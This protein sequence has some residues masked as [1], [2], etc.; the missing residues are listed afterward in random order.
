MTTTLKR[1]A[2]LNKTWGFIFALL[3]FAT[4][5]LWVPPAG[6]AQS[7]TAAQAGDAPQ[8]AMLA[9]VQ[10]WVA[11]QAGISTRQVELGP[12]D[13]RLKVPGCGS[14]LSFEYAFGGREMVR[15]HC[16]SPS[17]DLYVKARVRELRA[18]L[19]VT[20]A[21][22]A[23]TVLERTDLEASLSDDPVHG[24]RVDAAAA[25]GKRL[26]IP[27]SAGATISAGDLEEIR[28]IYRL[29]SAVTAGS[30][31]DPAQWRA[32]DVAR[33]SIPA[34][35]VLQKPP[36]PGAR[37]A[38]D[39]AAGRVLAQGDIAETRQALVAKENIAAG[40]PLD[41]ELFAVRTLNVPEGS[42]P[43]IS[44]F[45][46][47]EFQSATRNI[48]AGEP[49]LATD[50]RPAVIVNRGQTVLVTLSAAIGLEISVRAEAM[51]DGRLSES[52]RL[53]NPESGKLLYGRVTG[54]GTARA[55]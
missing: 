30:P 10:R 44:E 48:P 29:L 22:T 33:S 32:D 36:G 26:R 13:G 21:L 15:V 37:Y 47:L 28:R 12:L 31:T 20:R 2:T 38:R 49:L 25:I 41:K 11:A 50:L 35:A 54:R 45:A 19:R 9:G 8:S 18:V 23:G 52:I 6:A 14:E 51:E 4:P 42:R 34:A 55:L 39:L 53:R 27:L 43:F 40:R 16:A 5:L 3:L 17:W 1:Q 24:E 7:A 46:G